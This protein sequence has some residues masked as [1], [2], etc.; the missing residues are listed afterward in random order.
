M[1][2]L[3]WTITTMP[4][5]TR[6]NPGSRHVGLGL[7]A[8]PLARIVLSGAVVLCLACDRPSEGGVRPS[9]DA[10]GSSLSGP[11]AMGRVLVSGDFLGLPD[12]MRVIGRRLVVLDD[13]GDPYVHVFDR[14]NGN[15]VRSLGNTGE[16]PGDYQGPWE[17]LSVP[18]ETQFA[19]IFD[20]TLKRITRISVEDGVAQESGFRTINLVGAGNLRR[21]HIPAWINDSELIAYG[22]FEGGSLVNIG[23]DG[24]IGSPFG[25]PLPGGDTIPYI[26]R[27]T[28]YQGRAAF[29]P[30][31]QLVARSYLNAGRIDIWDFSGRTIATADVPEPFDPV[32][33]Y[34]TQR[35]EYSFRVTANGN[36]SGYSDI[37]VTEDYVFALFSGQPMEAGQPPP[38]GGDAVHVYDWSGTYMG[39]F[40]LGQ[41][42]ASAI[43]VDMESMTLWTANR[44]PEPQIRV[45]SLIGLLPEFR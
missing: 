42:G 10:D 31:R 11:V 14:E 35:D 41:P 27:L 18:G 19:W 13:S 34:S 29:E 17:I 24:A 32:F 16:G 21:V 6:T 30:S 22:G 40:R 15:L 43:A 45:H 23:I 44:R 7:V 33:S 36:R 8:Y 5:M 9:V 28:A 39:G 1:A 3:S 4:L 37:E 12:E 20:L 25:P 38:E 2:T 26:A